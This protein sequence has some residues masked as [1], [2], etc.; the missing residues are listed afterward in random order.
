MIYERAMFNSCN[1]ESNE[2]FE[3]YLR[4]LKLLIQTCDF[5]A[6]ED[7]LLRDRLVLGVNNKK[8]KKKLIAKADLKLT[9]TI[10]MC[11]IE[12]E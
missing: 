12:D 9:D 6:V 11:R 1:Q 10:D 2:K 3:D 4:K 8:L 5:G 7:D